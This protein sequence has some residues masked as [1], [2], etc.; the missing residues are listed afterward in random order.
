MLPCLALV[1]PAAERGAAPGGREERAQAELAAHNQL[2]TQLTLLHHQVRSQNIVQPGY[3]VPR[4]VLA[5]AY[6]TPVRCGP[7]IFCFATADLAGQCVAASSLL[8][9]VLQCDASRKV[10]FR[11]HVPCVCAYPAHPR[12]QLD[13]RLRGAGVVTAACARAQ[14]VPGR[15]G[16]GGRADGGAAGGARALAAPAGRRA[17]RARAQ[18]GALPAPDGGGQGARLRGGAAARAR[19]GAGVVRPPGGGHP[20]GA[21]GGA[22]P[23]PG[24]WAWLPGHGTSQSVDCRGPSAV[25]VGCGTQQWAR[26]S[27][28]TLCM[29]PGASPCHALPCS[30][31]STIDGSHASGFHVHR[32]ARAVLQWSF[33]HE[34]AMHSALQRSCT[35]AVARARR[36]ARRRWPWTAGSTGRCCCACR[37]SRWR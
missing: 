15:A 35:D 3:F 9:S 8:S 33:R 23:R 27:T 31:C 2:V 1:G 26:Y 4:N 5:D 24:P 14:A 28:L 21:G 11:V 13:G 29:P 16:R 12:Y 20:R 32:H 34:H 25:L 19:Q 10:A 7:W 37:R 36:S 17:Q 30:A 18:R 6:Y 22:R